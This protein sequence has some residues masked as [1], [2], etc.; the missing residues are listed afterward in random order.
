MNAPTETRPWPRIIAMVDMNAFFASIE[1]HDDPNLAGKP[2]AVTNGL[3]GTCVITCSYEARA[4]GV[5]TGMHIKAARRLCPGLIRRPARPQRYARISTHIMAA[6]ETITPVLEVFSVDEAFL[7]VT[8]CQQLWGSPWDIA[9][10]VKQR[11]RECCGLPCSVG[12]SSDKSTAKYA[13]KLHKPDGLTIIPPWEA[14]QWLEQVPVMELCGV[15]R[16]GPGRPRCRG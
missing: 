9:R 16:A 15:N 12:V 13:A 5:H 3:V 4:R 2:V 10:L 11:V 7:D 6:L 8:R 14:R 1:Q